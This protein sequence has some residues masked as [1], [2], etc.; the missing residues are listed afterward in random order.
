MT[1]DALDYTAIATGLGGGLALFLYGMRKMTESLK[2]VAGSGL[3]DV[4]ARLTTNRL[5]G[6]LSGALVTSV[7]QSSSATTVMV[8]GFVSSGLITFTQSVGVIMGA[9]VGTTITAQVVAFDVARYSLA[10]IAVGFLMELLATIGLAG[11]FAAVAD[12]LVPRRQA[13]GQPEARRPAHLDPLFLDQPAVALD[14]VKLELLRL[15]EMAR[16]MAVDA[17]PAALR[18]DRATLEQLAA[19]D[20]DLD[21]LHGA[22]VGYLGELSMRDLVEPLP[23]RLQECLGIANDL[24]TVGDIVESGFVAVGCKRVDAN[25]GFTSA[26]TERLERLGANALREYEQAVDAFRDRDAKAARRVLASKGA[27]NR[28]AEEVAVAL[29]APMAERNANSALVE[30]R[31]AIALVDETK[32]LH[33]LARRISRGVVA[34]RPEV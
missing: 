22:I 6:A 9:N 32:R 33:T 18:G 26:T 11:S 24:E 29:V 10:M 8:V 21:E 13:R 28:A 17:L 15:A 16:V 14:R 27:F 3:K 7:I 19:R 30:Y 20:D 5:T 31:L 23:R 25:F 4:L 2:T 34:A 1:P 12:R